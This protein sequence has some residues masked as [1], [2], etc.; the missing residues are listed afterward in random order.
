MNIPFSKS[1]PLFCFHVPCHM[2]HMHPHLCVSGAWSGSSPLATSVVES[3]LPVS[4][5]LIMLLTPPT[6]L[7]TFLICSSISC[8]FW[9]YVFKSSVLVFNARIYWNGDVER[10]RAISDLCQFLNISRRMYRIL[11]FKSLFIAV[12]RMRNPFVK[13]STCNAR[14]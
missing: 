5:R 10:L 1:F 9:K 3:R 6:L 2:L 14:P 7:E 11:F 13:Y 8:N 4:V 12:R